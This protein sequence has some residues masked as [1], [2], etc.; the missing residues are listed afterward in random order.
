M[1]ISNLPDKQFKIM[2]RK[3]FTKFKRSMNT[4]RASTKRW[5]I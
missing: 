3:M 5:G 2:I 4:E 1:K